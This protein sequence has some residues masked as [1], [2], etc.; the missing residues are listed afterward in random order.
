MP[1]KFEEIYKGELESDGQLTELVNQKFI[2]EDVEFKNMS[3]KLGEVALVQV[4]LGGQKLKLH[5]F[6]SVLIKQ[7]RAIKQYI[8]KNNDTVEVTL[9]KTKNYYTFE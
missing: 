3:G 8:N 7:L 2:V 6:S 9:R 4:D 1:K 5:T